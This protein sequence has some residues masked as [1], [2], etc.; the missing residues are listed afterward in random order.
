MTYEQKIDELIGKHV[1]EFVSELSLAKKLE[2]HESRPPMPYGYPVSVYRPIHICSVPR[3]RH[4]I[5]H[6][7]GKL[8][9]GVPRVLGMEVV[10]DYP[11]GIYNRRRC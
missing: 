5:E 11:L 10:G 3:V 8:S 6:N 9:N 7:G 2:G 1:A 4:F